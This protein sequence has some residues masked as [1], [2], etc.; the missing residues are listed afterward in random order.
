M[1]RAGR[2]SPPPS[3]VRQAAVQ[4]VALAWRY[5]L[6]FGLAA[7]L[8]AAGGMIAW[9]ALALQT[10]RHPAPLFATRQAVD[11]APTP[12]PPNR[13]LVSEAA[14]EPHPAPMLQPS[15]QVQNP[16][17]AAREAI[18]DPA[19]PEAA[20]VAAPRP[21][22]AAVPLPV[23]RPATQPAREARRDPIAELIRAGGEAPIPPGF[24]G[25]PEAT[26]SVEQGQ[27]ALE[28][29][30]YGP[31]RADGIMGSATRQAIERFE[32]DH[33]LPVTGELGARTS[34]ELAN[35]SGIAIE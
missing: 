7:A 20:P 26:L 5:P 2:Q 33:R 6:E 14:V 12:L 21:A 10:A 17:R 1:R 18:T 19:R 15:T 4:A 27:R 28:K 30:G 16:P 8:T 29:L 24:V 25:R 31:L 34:R 11:A 35:A 32:K 9:N 3:L 13:P 23:P 22:P